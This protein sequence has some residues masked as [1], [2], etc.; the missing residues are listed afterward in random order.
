MF[1]TNFKTLNFN[2]LDI[3]L[4]NKRHLIAIIVKLIIKVNFVLCTQ[5][6][7]IKKKCII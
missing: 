4:K 3:R 2:L 5:G 1:K 7:T 6:G